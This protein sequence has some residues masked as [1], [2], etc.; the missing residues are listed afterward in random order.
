[1]TSRERVLATFAHC[2]PDR[3]PA[4]CGA[5][6][7]FWA[8]AKRELSLDDEGLRVRFGDDFRRVQARYVGPPVEL[9]PGATYA[10]PFGIQRHGLGY[11]QPMRHPLA[12]ATLTQVHL[13][14]IH[15]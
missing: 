8:A 9:A 2:E 13:S 1:M 4:W 11:G 14:L 3:V 7:E 12:D 10:T 15:I 6:E 5:S